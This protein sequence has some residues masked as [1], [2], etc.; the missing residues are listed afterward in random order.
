MSNQNKPLP[1][2]EKLPFFLNP[3][4]EIVQEPPHPDLVTFVLL[5]LTTLLGLGC[6]LDHAL[7]IASNTMLET[8]WGRFYKGWNLGG[9]KVKKEWMTD[10]TWWWRAPGHIES[11]DPPWCYYM[12]FTS[13]A[14]FFLFWLNRYVRATTGRYRKCSEQFQAG[15]EWFDDLIDAGYK[16]EVT[17][18]NPEP[19]LERHEV[20]IDTLGRF[21]A[22]HTVDVKV[23]GEWGPKSRVAALAWQK[24]KGV[25]ETGRYQDVLDSMGSRYFAGGKSPN[26]VPELESAPNPKSVA[27][28]QPVVEPVAVPVVVVELAKET[29]PEAPEGA[30]EVVLEVDVSPSE[31]E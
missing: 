6:S 15:A 7:G 2:P 23:D 21:W 9:V 25:E 28:V 14:A 27:P 19:S 16:G 8:G 30:P 26:E 1:P 17:R 29:A 3:V 31:S 5:V 12:G 13:M 22:Q 10:E 24:R 18:M 11:G 4:R 20:I